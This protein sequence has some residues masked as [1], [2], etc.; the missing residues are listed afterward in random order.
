M[1]STSDYITVG[2]ECCCFTI[3]GLHQRNTIGL[4]AGLVPKVLFLQSFKEFKPFERLVCNH[5]MAC[6]RNSAIALRRMNHYFRQRF[7]I[8]EIE[9]VVGHRDI[10]IICK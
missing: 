7:N 2:R 3:N 6:V 8:H 4:E 5:M 1:R 9:I 10:P